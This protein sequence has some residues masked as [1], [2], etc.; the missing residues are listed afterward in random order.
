MSIGAWVGTDLTYT[1]QWYVCDSEPAAVSTAAS[2]LVDC[3][4]IAGATAAS[5]QVAVSNSGK[6]F[7]ASVTA[8]TGTVST[9]AYSQFVSPDEFTTGYWTKRVGDNVKI[10]AKN[11]IGLG[12]VQFFVNGREIAWATP[13]SIADTKLRVIATGPQAGDSYLVRDR[14]LVDGRNFFDIKLNGV[15]VE[16]RVAYKR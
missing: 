16:S 14:D 4:V 15:V 7:V 3:T 6:Y 11:F 12:K 1:Y 9:T 13:L 10:Y 2:V 5:Y 8:T